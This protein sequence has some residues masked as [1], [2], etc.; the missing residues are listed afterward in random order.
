MTSGPR[1][2]FAAAAISGRVIDTLTG[3]PIARARIEAGELASVET[4]GSGFFA[5]PS[6]LSGVVALGVEAEGHYPRETR[7]RVGAS[8][9]VEIDLL[10]SDKKFDLDFFDHVYR[11]VGEDGTHPWTSEPA[12][13]ILDRIHY[14]VESNPQ[15]FC[16]V[17]EATE[18][19]VPGQFMS[20]SQQVIAEDASRYTGGRVTGASVVTTAV[21]PGSRIV[22]TDAWVR[23]Q[24]RFV[25]VQLRDDSSWAT[26]WHYRG[27]G[28]MY[29]GLVMINKQHKALRG[30]YSHEL[31]HTLGYYHPR[32][33]DEVPLPSIMRYGH[34]EAPDSNDILHGAIL[35]RRPPGS[36][37]PDRDPE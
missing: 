2:L 7:V 3:E 17:L 25:L 37:T 33:G 21:D 32:G 18:E 20:L 29:S 28:S 5:L 13:Q 19:S 34:D 36:R 1:S 9:T 6:S 15:G 12:F 16:D 27:S 23:D 24:V 22:R 30:V 10:P 8:E 26:T 4:D 31:A 35:Y 11:D 14:C